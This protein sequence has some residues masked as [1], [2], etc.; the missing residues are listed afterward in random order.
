MVDLEVEAGDL[1]KTAG[2]H[3]P[4]E[5]NQG[6]GLENVEPVVSIQYIHSLE[7]AV[8]SAVSHCFCRLLDRVL[9]VLHG[10]MTRLQMALGVLPRVY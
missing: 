4:N 2:R 6:I 8:E 1:G 10:F 7:I 5:R 9:G 3:D